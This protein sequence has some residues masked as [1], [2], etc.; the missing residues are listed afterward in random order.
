MKMFRKPIAPKPY[1]NCIGGEPN[2]DSKPDYFA[3]MAKHDRHMRRRYTVSRIARDLTWLAI[4]SLMFSMNWAF[5]FAAAFG[6][7]AVS[8]WQACCM[9]VCVALVRNYATRPP[10]SSD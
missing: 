7:P 8:W 2:Y 9:L 10:P 5:G 4:A 3:A 1:S 6:W